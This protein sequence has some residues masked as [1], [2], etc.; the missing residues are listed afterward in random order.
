MNILLVAQ[1]C[2][3]VTMTTS[4]SRNFS[5]KR[6]VVLFLPQCNAFAACGFF[7]AESSA[8]QWLTSA[9]S[10]HLARAGEA[11]VVSGW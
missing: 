5:R 7:S 10:G 2:P 3:C 6:K 9:L 4:E 8:A 1:K 11:G